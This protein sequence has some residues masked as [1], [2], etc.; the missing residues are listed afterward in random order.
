VQAGHRGRAQGLSASSSW[1]TSSRPRT[2]PRA[3]GAEVVLCPTSVF[4]HPRA[5][6]RSPHVLPRHP[7]RVQAR[8]STER[9]EP[10]LTNGR[11]ARNCGPRPVGSP[12]VRA[13]G[14]RHSPAPLRAPQDAIHHPGH[15][16][17]PEG[18]VLSGVRPAVSDRGVGKTSARHGRP[19]V[20]D[21]RSV[22]AIAMRSR[23]PVG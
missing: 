16:C 22:S 12:F 21:R 10:G 2:A 17:G 20:V 23:W 4:G 9:G 7:R 18:S 14:M 3:Y 6:T 19:S 13:S 1:P 11:P 5:T 15:R 8:T